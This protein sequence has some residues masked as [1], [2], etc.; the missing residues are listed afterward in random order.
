[1]LVSSKSLSTAI[2]G[3]MSCVLVGLL[4]SK[5]RYLTALTGSAGRSQGAVGAPLVGH[6]VTGQS[7][8]GSAAPLL[9]VNGHLSFP[10]RESS[11][12]Y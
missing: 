11:L 7:E 1:M 4:V 2:V 9:L 3:E 6:V 12:F 10:G 8:E 5:C